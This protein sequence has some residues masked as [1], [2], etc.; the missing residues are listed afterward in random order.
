MNPWPRDD[1]RYVGTFD[2]QVADAKKSR[3]SQ[4]RQF[5]QKFYGASNGEFVVVGQFDP[6]QVEKLAAELF[7]NWKGPSR[8]ERLANNYGKIE[9]MD[10]KLETPDKQN[11]LFLAGMK[12]K[13]NDDDPDY[14]AMVLGNYIL[15]GSGG[16][17]LFK[18]VR[19]KEGLSYGVGSGFGAPT[20][21][22]GAMF[23]TNAICNPQNL[24]KAEAS[25]KDELARTVGHRLQRR[26][27]GGRSQ[28]IVARKPGGE[29]V[30]GPGF[31]GNSGYPRVLGTGPLNGTRHSK[32]K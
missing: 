2:E 14:A 30:T 7:G 5:Y 9:P 31:A 17:R 28:K 10:K 26:S 22:D 20:K 32:P 29:P 6:A 24:P 3:S 4:M 1:V 15:G 8:Y 21:D 13:M 27:A 12:V 18:R 25:I 19:D 23:S 16:S 11:A